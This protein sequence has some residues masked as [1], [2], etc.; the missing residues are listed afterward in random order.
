MEQ[1]R[2]DMEAEI[3]DMEQESTA[4]LKVLQATIGDLSDL[5][6][7]RLRGLG[8]EDSDLAQ[9]VVEGLKRLEQVCDESPAG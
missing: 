5:R 6:Y 9:D 1:A 2:L 3:A 7:G 8:G 4:I